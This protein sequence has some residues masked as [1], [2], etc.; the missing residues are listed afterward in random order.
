MLQIGGNGFANIRRQR[1]FGPSSAFAPHC[2]LAEFPINIFKFQA[3]DFAGSESKPGKQHQ[4][5]VIAPS[6]WSASISPRRI[7]STVPVGRNLGIVE[8]E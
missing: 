5:R 7:F 3:D 4:H 2:D 1:H 6:S 8:N